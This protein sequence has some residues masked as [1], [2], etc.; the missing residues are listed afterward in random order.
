MNKLTL[1]RIGNFFLRTIALFM[2][3]S[4][5]LMFF[6]G[7]FVPESIGSIPM[8]EARGQPAI[9]DYPRLF[10]LILGVMAMVCSMIGSLL[11]L[12]SFLRS[13][14][15]W[16]SLIFI[17]IASALNLVFLDF[18]AFNDCIDFLLSPAP[19]IEVGGKHRTIIY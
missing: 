5:L 2:T 14:R 1:I 4:L 13:R 3:G 7:L 10:G 18:T 12:S 11:F 17:V 15:W 8:I 9:V 19:T 6:T 16:V